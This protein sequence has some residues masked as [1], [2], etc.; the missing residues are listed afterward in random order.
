MSRLESVADA[1]TMQGV[2][3]LALA[4]EECARYE[5]AEF[6]GQPVTLRGDARLLC[7]LIRN[8]LE[9]SRRHGAPPIE[10]R[11]SCTDA[12][13]R[14]GSPITARECGKANTSACL[15]LSTA[16]RVRPPGRGSASRSCA[17]SRAGMAGR[18]TLHQAK[19]DEAPW[20]WSC[21]RRTPE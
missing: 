1:V 9:N 10:L 21:R 17:G 20:S 11:V 13:P 8:L 19:A 5:E 6:D 14:F 12:G 16:P 2:D 18:H 3:L 15:S 4:A 7:R